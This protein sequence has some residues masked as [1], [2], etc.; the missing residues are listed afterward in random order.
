[1]AVPKKAT[2]KAKRDSRRSHHALKTKSLI[3]CPNCGDAML[4]HR[5]CSGCGFYKGK[6]VIQL[7][8]D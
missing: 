8:E 4:L 5:I 3:S 7:E 1:M 2:S 6:E